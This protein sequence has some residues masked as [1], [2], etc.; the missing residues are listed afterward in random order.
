MITYTLT[1]SNEGTQFERVFVYR[2]PN[3]LFAALDALS[4]REQIE[5]E[6]VEALRRLKFEL[7]KR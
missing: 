5:A 2:R 6:S 1:P 7:E 4:L 3:L